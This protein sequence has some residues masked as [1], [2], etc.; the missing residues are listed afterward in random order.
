MHTALLEWMVLAV[1]LTEDVVVEVPWLVETVVT[2]WDDAAPDV[3]ET[4]SDDDE[5]TA[6]VESMDV[7]CVVDVLVE[8]SVRH[9][10]ATQY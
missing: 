9:V 4:E 6:D 5:A 8:A 10:P 2:P 3:R 1:E 7:L